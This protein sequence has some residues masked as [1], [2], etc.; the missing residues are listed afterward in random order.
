MNPP[1]VITE[2]NGD[3][4]FAIERLAVGAPV[5]AFECRIGEYSTK[6]SATLWTDARQPAISHHSLPAFPRWAAS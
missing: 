5:G 1:V 2:D 4:Y 3:D 6:L